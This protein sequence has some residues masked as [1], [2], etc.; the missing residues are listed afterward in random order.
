MD[1]TVRADDPVGVPVAVILNNVVRRVD[2]ADRVPS[3]DLVMNLDN[4]P[5][6]C[7]PNADG[8]SGLGVLK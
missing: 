3:R 5:T 4:E 2:A 8:P 6:E 7:V 1:A